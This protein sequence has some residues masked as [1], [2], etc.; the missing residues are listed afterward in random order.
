M[1]TTTT[2]AARRP[3]AV[4][5]VIGTPEWPQVVTKVYA[6]GYVSDPVRVYAMTHGA[7]TRGAF[8]GALLAAAAAWVGYAPGDRVDAADVTRCIGVAYRHGINGFLAAHVALIAPAVTHADGTPCTGDACTDCA[9]LAAE[10]A[11]P[12]APVMVG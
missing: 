7:M 2:A 4:G 3:L 8:R 5:D 11:L 10:R 9:D 6:S 12:D 1:F